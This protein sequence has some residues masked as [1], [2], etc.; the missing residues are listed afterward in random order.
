MAR[1]TNRLSLSHREVISLFLI[2]LN[3]FKWNTL[4]RTSWTYARLFEKELVPD[5]YFFMS[6]RF[7]GKTTM[8]WRPTE[9]WDV[10]YWIYIWF[11]FSTYIAYSYTVVF[12][13]NCCFV[14][15]STKFFYMQ[16]FS[17][18]NLFP[19]NMYL[20]KSLWDQK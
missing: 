19:Y 16:Y 15:V 17:K 14:W 8:A 18:V 9:N 10:W 11:Y 13:N 20:H 5:T 7:I 1:I 12:E 3:N 4:D 2:V 6:L